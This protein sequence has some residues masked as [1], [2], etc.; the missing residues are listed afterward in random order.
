M[1]VIITKADPF[2]LAIGADHLLMYIVLSI[3]FLFSLA[4]NFRH[5]E[6]EYLNSILLTIMA[7]SFLFMIVRLNNTLMPHY[8]KTPITVLALISLITLLIY[9]FRQSDLNR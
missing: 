9:Q 3:G 7:Y 2:S 5:K 1:P 8:S 6:E 4:A